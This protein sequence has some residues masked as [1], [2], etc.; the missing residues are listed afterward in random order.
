[1][2]KFECLLADHR[3]KRKRTACDFDKSYEFHN[4]QRQEIEGFVK[5]KMLHC[6][7]S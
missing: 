6:I 3:S 1:M 2:Q 7:W 4:K 5:L